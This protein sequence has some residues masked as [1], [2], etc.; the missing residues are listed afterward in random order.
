[1]LLCRPVRAVRF[2]RVWIMTAMTLEERPTLDR[3]RARE[4][5]LTARIAGAET[6]TELTR[7]FPH[8][9][10]RYARH[11]K[12]GDACL[13][14]DERGRPAAMGWV[15]F[16]LGEAVEEL[17]CRLELP[18]DACWGYDTFILPRHRGRGAFA[19]L[20]WEM[21]KLVKQRGCRAIYASMNHLNYASLASHRRLGY[22]TA[23]VIERI[24]LIRMTLYR[25]SFPGAPGSWRR[26]RSRAGPTVELGESRGEET[27]S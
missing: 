11:W 15:R 9:G 26:M 5:D 16:D 2:D 3:L 14:V 18:P 6:E 24:V 10:S 7:V 8:E 1:M 22:A 21:F 19:V 17:G 25:V 12:R 27:L 20:M 4:A 23:A 13:M